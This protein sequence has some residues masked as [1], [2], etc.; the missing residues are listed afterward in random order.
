MCEG[1]PGDEATT[2]PVLKAGHPGG[3]DMWNKNITQ[4][5][6]FY[7]NEETTDSILV[8]HWVVCQ[9]SY[10]YSLLMKLERVKQPLSRDHWVVIT[11]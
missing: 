1:E 5:T 3:G 11:F 7:G 6:Y 10:A 2:V 8:H 9:T 4:A